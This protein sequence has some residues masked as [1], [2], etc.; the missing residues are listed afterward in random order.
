MNDDFLYEGRPEFPPGLALKIEARLRQ[1]EQ[2][3]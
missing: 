2:H 1:L 3:N